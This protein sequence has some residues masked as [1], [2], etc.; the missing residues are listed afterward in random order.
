VEA[1]AHTPNRLVISIIARFNRFYTDHRQNRGGKK[2]KYINNFK[3]F[4]VPQ[5][6][7]ST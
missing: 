4:T 3:R 6:N 2:Y 7:D 1:V 5:W